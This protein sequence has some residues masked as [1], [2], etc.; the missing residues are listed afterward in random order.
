MLA[1][2]LYR[3]FKLVRCKQLF[4]GIEKELTSGAFDK[5][6]LRE[7][8]IKL[9]A[10]GLQIPSIIYAL[11]DA[12]APICNEESIDKSARNYGSERWMLAQEIKKAWRARI[13]ERVITVFVA[14]SKP[15]IR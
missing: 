7:R 10:R 3:N 2:A 6:T 14:A 9:E 15:T 12:A 8:L 4:D 5:V 11:L 13:G 1:P